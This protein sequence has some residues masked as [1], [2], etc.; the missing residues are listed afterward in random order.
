MVSTAMPGSLN[1]GGNG[2]SYGPVVSAD[3][4]YV[5]FQSAASNLTPPGGPGIPLG[6]GPHW[7]NVFLR[8]RS[9]TVT[10]LVSVNPAGAGGNCN[11]GPLAISTNGQYVL[12]ES[13]ATDLTPGDTNSFN[14]LFVRDVV[15]GITTCVSV[16]TN[17]VPGNGSSMHGVMTP[18]GR[19]VA[20]MSAAS[21]LA[22]NDTNGIPDVFVRD[23]Q[24]GTTTLV[25]AGAL[26]PVN[27]PGWAVWPAMSDYPVIST[28]GRY[29]AFVSSATNLV[30]GVRV[31]T[32]VYER[33]LIAGTT[34]W[35]STN[36]ALIFKNVNVQA[37]T[38]VSSCCPVIDATGRYVAYVVGC[39]PSAS[40]SPYAAGVHGACLRYDLQMQTTTVIASNA[41]VPQGM[42]FAEI[43]DEEAMTPDGGAI[44]FVN[45]DSSSSG[46]SLIY[47]W[48]T[49][50]F[51]T[52]VLITADR[53]T[54]QQVPLA[55]AS[56][57]SISDDGH[58][59]A[60]Q[61]GGTNL[62]TN[63]L[64]GS[65]HLY[66]YNTPAGTNYLVDV[67]TNGIG[68][69]QGTQ[70][71]MSSDGRFIAFDSPAASI[72]PNDGNR[73]NDVFGYNLASNIAELISV[74]AS[75]PVQSLPNGISSIDAAALSSNAQYV[76]FASDADNLAP[77]DT[78]SLADVF[79]HD[80]V[81]GTNTLAS[82]AT[83]GYSA[84]RWS[85][86]PS[87]SGDGHFLAFSSFATNLV[88]GNINVIEQV[89]RR[90][91]RAGTNALISTT[92]SGG[93]GNGNSFQ[94]TISSDGRFVLF[95]SIASNLTNYPNQF[96]TGLY[97]R[98]VSSKLTY[99]LTTN[100]VTGASMTPDGHFVAFTSYTGFNDNLYVRDNF[101]AKNIYTNS[102]V[103]GDVG[104]SPDGRWVAFD[105][106]TGSTVNT[107]D[108]IYSTNGP[109]LSWGILDSDA[110]LQF[111]TS[112]RYLVCATKAKVVKSDLNN[113]YDV[114]CYDFQTHSNVLVSRSYN[115]TNA[116]NGP[117]FLPCISPDGH[118][119]AYYSLAKNIV[120]NQT[121]NV[122]NIF[123]YDLT[124]DTTLL[125][126][127]NQAGTSTASAFSQ[128]PVFSPDSS[129]LAF[130]SFAPDLAGDPL[131]GRDAIYLL[132]LAEP[133]NLDTNSIATNTFVQ[134]NAPAGAAGL[135]AKPILTWPTFFGVSYRIQYKTNLTD[136]VWQNLNGNATIL[137]NQGQATDF[138]PASQRFYRLSIVY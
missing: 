90:D 27:V 57:P 76:A 99:L 115:S 51:P 84:N 19:Y 49:N 82:V 127:A 52:N 55:S 33:D 23:L 1:A 128:Q 105:V 48:N 83:N 17:G 61:C 13:T 66:I 119:I 25:S 112:D 135:T 92:P 123:L 111:S 31:G 32:E 134:L 136:P 43:S 67:S 50:E 40:P 29:V 3:G 101:A 30:G 85:G 87:I 34:T 69:G 113:T 39:W 36:A 97:L 80:N 15:N 91:L 38:N 42:N 138:S 71:G 35:I 122:G 14:N 109:T 73:D 133:A 124:S 11:S 118:Y 137:G 47:L 24:A 20:F 78:N 16:N 102:T 53:T 129:T 28:N 130:R 81:S 117:S 65:G 93:V 4:R 70:Y 60:Y 88:G 121:S 107:R 131:N 7:L 54:G 10:T 9:N 89:Y 18:D 77:N 132:N 86:Q 62:T 56:Q 37:T 108:L 95:Y 2:D 75:G 22:P 96:Q 59:V 26:V 94:P 63:P 21:D 64:Q 125:I 79:V 110:A 44:A 45:N 104:I 12:F 6:P 98:D 46:N 120:P 68:V 8:D 74:A 103:Y 106:T 116:A 41:Y 58:Y 5:A 114:Y 126:S 72:V 100:Q